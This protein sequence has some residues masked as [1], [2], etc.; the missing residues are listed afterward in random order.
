MSITEHKCFELD[1]RHWAWFKFQSMVTAKHFTNFCDLNCAR[2]QGSRRRWVTVTV[3]ILPIPTPLSDPF[4]SPVSRFIIFLM[5]PSCVQAG[6]SELWLMARKPYS[7]RMYSS[8]HLDQAM[9]WYNENAHLIHAKHNYVLTR[10]TSNENLSSETRR[11]G[12]A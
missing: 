2:T 10:Y 7:T 5:Q 12:R 8:Q 1:F 4:S 9:S 3:L 6:S 11:T